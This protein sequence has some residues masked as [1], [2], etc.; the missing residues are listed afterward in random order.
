[1]IT[2][3]LAIVVAMALTLGQLECAAQCAVSTCDVSLPASTQNLPPCHR[4]HSDSSKQSPVSPC[5]HGVAIANVA[6]SSLAHVAAPV[7]MVASLIVELQSNS[8]P[9][10]P[11]STFAALTSSPPGS[12]GPS[13][14]ILRI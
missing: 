6:D 7:L 3:K 4:H 8:Q 5:L 13:S 2:G 11:G 9:P 10:M 12:G 14:L 1:M